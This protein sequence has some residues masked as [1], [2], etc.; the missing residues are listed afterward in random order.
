MIKSTT[1]STT[2][3]NKQQTTQHT[4]HHTTHNNCDKNLMGPMTT[5]MNKTT[6]IKTAKIT[7]TENNPKINN[8]S[9]SLLVVFLYVLAASYFVVVLLFEYVYIANLWCGSS[10]NLFWG[11]LQNFRSLANAPA[12]IY[13]YMYTH[14]DRSTYTC[15]KAYCCELAN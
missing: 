14:K 9:F 8:W 1:K 4:T 6:I 12:C 3:N 15:L 5:T 10:A 11:F 7:A 2:P 13:V